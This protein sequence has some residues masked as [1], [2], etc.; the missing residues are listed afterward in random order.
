MRK[1]LS[2]E[3]RKERRRISLMKYNKSEKSKN[4]ILRFKASAQYKI[5]KSKSHL[6]ERHYVKDGAWHLIEGYERLLLDGCSEIN[7][8]NKWVLH[9]RKEAL[10]SVKEL[11]EKGLY[12]DC[13]PSDLI[14]LT[15][16]E[17]NQLHQRIRKCKKETLRFFYNEVIVC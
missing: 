2:D 17:H 14:W 12:Y 3:E 1:K 4:R 8:K 16:T 7:R 9:H 6:K 5:C 10:Y 15:R 13:P 11:I